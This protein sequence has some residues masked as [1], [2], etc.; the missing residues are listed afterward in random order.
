M[1]NPNK[2][3]L[4]KQSKQHWQ[5]AE[6][7]LSGVMDGFYNVSDADIEDSCMFLEHLINAKQIKT[8]HIIDCAAGI[9]R[10]IEQAFIKYFD[11][12]DLLEQDQKFIEY[13][14]KNIT[15]YP[16][17]KNIFCDSLQNFQFQSTYDVV[18]TQWGLQNLDEEDAIDFLT[19]S[20][21]NLTKNGVIIAKEN[22]AIDENIITISDGSIIRNNTSFEKIFAKCDLKII[23][24][25]TIKNWNEEF[26]PVKTFVLK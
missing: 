6:A 18:W 25:N 17:I 19:R 24:Q 12:I 13:C 21:N 8:G 4:Y 16:Q 1:R 3:K 26:F 22:I 9:G 15:K 2:D 11:K 23:A 5:R 20:K 7:S 14:Q 10:V